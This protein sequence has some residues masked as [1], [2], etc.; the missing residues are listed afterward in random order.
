VRRALVVLL[1]GLVACGGSGSGEG[2]DAVTTTTS[3]TAPLHA[4]EDLDDGTHFGFVTALDPGHF[5]L[6]FDEAELLSGEEA[7]RAAS[8]DGTV[9]TSGGSY[10]RNRDDRMNNVTIAKDIQ[11]RLLRP[12]CELHRVAFEDWLASFEP[13]D[14]TFYGTSK[15]YYELTI[16]DGKVEKVDEVLVR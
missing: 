6:V 8:E 15:S 16:V 11:V 9:V 5:R 7:Q 2:R 12:C 3:S 13:D 1:A 4:A 14:R 10:V